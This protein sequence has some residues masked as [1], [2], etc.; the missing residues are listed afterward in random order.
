MSRIYDDKHWAS[1]VFAG[2]VLGYAVGTLIMNRDNWKVRI[3]ASPTGI[4]LT[5]SL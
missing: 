4:T 2:A 1:D 5:G 3:N